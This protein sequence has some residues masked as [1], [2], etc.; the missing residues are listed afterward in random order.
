[1]ERMYRGEEDLSQ[2]SFPQVVTPP[3]SR[4]SGI[5]KRRLVVHDEKRSAVNLYVVIM[6]QNPFHVA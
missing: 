6:K 3:E 5:W 4:G 1:M 2:P